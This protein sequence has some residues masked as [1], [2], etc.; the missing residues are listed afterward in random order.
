[1]ASLCR[2]LSLHSVGCA[3][4]WWLYMFDRQ[5][6]DSLQNEQLYIFSLVCV[7]IW[8]CNEIVSLSL[9]SIQLWVE[10]KTVY[11]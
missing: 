10:C 6:N 11:L 4:F 8:S 2:L 3:R 9:L 7:A 5:M 1:M